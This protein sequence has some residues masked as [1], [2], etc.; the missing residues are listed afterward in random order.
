MK[1]GVVLARGGEHKGDG[2]INQDAGMARYDTPNL[3][4]DSGVRYDEA[5]PAPPPQRSNQ[6][7]RPVWG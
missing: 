4:Y 1:N 5:E 7:I 3:F 6:L 2:N